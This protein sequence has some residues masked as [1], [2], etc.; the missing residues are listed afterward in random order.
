[1]FHTTCNKA[2]AVRPKSD[3]MTFDAVVKILD[4]EPTRRQCGISSPRYLKLQRNPWN[5]LKDS[6]WVKPADNEV[7]LPWFHIEGLDLVDS[8]VPVDRMQG[9]SCQLKV[10]GD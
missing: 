7:G 1:M 8:N 6:T 5:T 10:N 2:T 3:T 9:S 4:K